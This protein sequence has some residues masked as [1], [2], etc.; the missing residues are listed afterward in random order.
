M[1]PTGFEIRVDD[2]GCLQV[3]GEVDLDT[4]AAFEA[5]IDQLMAASSPA[6]I[7]DLAA[8]TFF[9]SAA[10]RSLI[11]ACGDGRPVVLRGASVNVRRVLEITG[12]YGLFEQ[13]APG[14]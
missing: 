5:G 1:E 3:A 6:L 10:L 4:V 8:V 14:S 11:R 7:I 9:G 2:S 12:L 13:I